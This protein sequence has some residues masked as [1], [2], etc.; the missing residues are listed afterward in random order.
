MMPTPEAIRIAV[1]VRRT[2][3]GDALTGKQAKLYS[4]RLRREMG[5]PGLA[6]FSHADVG[7]YLDEAMWL[8]E[9]A[10]TEQSAEP[11]GNWRRGIRRAAEILEFLSQR[12]LRPAGSPMHLLAA[13]AYQVAG[14]PA[15]A[16]A[17]LKHL[18]T[19]EPVSVIVREFLQADFPAALEDARRFWR[20]K[21]VA[22]NLQEV[23]NLSTLGVKH[24]V[25]CVGT[26]CMYFKTGDRG[27]VERAIDKLH[28]LARGYLHSRDP[29]SYLL[30][31]LTAMAGSAFET[32]SLWNSIQPLSET[33]DEA[34]QAAFQQ[35]ARSA[36]INRQSVIWPAQAVGIA[37][38]REP[39]SFVLC[40]PTGSGK[41]T[42]AT[43]AV[44][45]SLFSR[46]EGP[47]RLEHQEADNLILY[48]VPS[49]ALAA[50]IERRFAQDL[51]GIAA[52]PVVITGLY[53]GIDWGPTDAWIQ[54]D[55]PT[56]V[57]CTFE[58]A[59]AL[60]RYLGVLFLHRV[61]LVVIDEAHM[62]EYRRNTVHP[63]MSDTSR[64]LRLELLGTRLIE[65]GEHYGFRI[66]A[67]SAVAATAAPAL[68]RWFASTP[69]AVPAT[70]EHR[71]TRQMLGRIEVSDHGQF[72]IRYDLMDGR[73]LRFEDE[74]VAETPFVPAPFPQLPERP[75]FA[76]PEKAMQATALWA[77]LHLAAERPDGT[78]PS[79]LISVTQNIGSFASE[80]IGR[81][82]DW[83]TDQLPA[84]RDHTIL[85][86]PLWQWCLASAA[87]YFG[88]DSVEYRLL[89]RGI[90]VHHGKMPGLL[91]RRLKVLMDR[92]YVRIIVATSTL[93]EGVNIPVTYL[94]IPNIYRA[95][96]CLSLQEFTNLI[97]RAGRPGVSTEGHALVLLPEPGAMP[98]D[99][100]RRKLSRQRSGY[101]T[102]V[103]DLER[104]TTVRA[105]ENAVGAASSPL[106]R[107]LAAIEESWGQLVHNGTPGQFE[108]WLEQT[109]VT[110]EPTDDSP[111]YE[112]LDTLDSFLLATI[113]ELEQLRGQEIPSADMEERL[114]TIWQRSYAFAAA[115]EEERLRRI[116]LGRGL[117]I[118][119]R[120]PDPAS[121]RQIYR[122]SLSPRAPL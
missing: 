68:A 62:V 69:D 13:A 102:L 64:E 36:F 121:R 120:Y 20:A 86:E 26:I 18:P 40:T 90:A 54:T 12:D 76:K 9:C 84:Y 94:L 91:A 32:S 8:I 34:M 113:Q 114:L 27:F 105:T 1:A 44:V 85:T 88:T 61:R 5:R 25:M 17:Q 14:F 35:F 53:G 110:A 119:T 60:L 56:I 82:T 71:S 63:P 73:S 4:Q 45:Q 57:I 23:M 28:A 38:L 80:C 103:R 39:T 117:A 21:P 118:K 46:P 47:L 37:R 97:G 111:A 115:R 95:N 51:H 122:T 83:P 3:A 52:T 101:A 7:D 99:R 108:Q 31:R 72:N 22:T 6:T 48:L 116:W 98:F 112:Y 79:V 74:Q 75:N 59:D 92:G 104:T 67:L 49:R 107:L 16:L 65:A 100:G 106:S 89:Q 58:K 33:A 55:T 2:L 19:D 30:A 66:I 11:N 43:L 77:A 109:S 78:R 93:S 29:Y 96:T 87:D 41:T 70:S 15:M 50:E 42:V 81:L 24:T 10:L